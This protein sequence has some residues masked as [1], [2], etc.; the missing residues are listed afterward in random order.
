MDQINRSELRRLIEMDR[1]PCVS[2]YLPTHRAGAD[3]LQDPIRLK[4][5]VREAE[6]LLGERSDQAPSIRD[7]LDPLRDLVDQYQFWQHQ[8]DGLA[9]FRSRDIFCRYRLSFTVPELAVAAPRFHLKPLLPA[10]EANQRFHVLALSQDAARV[11][12]GNSQSITEIKIK[13]MPEGP[14]ISSVSRGTERQLQSHTTGRESSRRRGAVFHGQGAGEEDRRQALL[15]YFRRVDETVRK[16]TDEQVPVV[17][18]AVD[19]LCPIYR[20]ASSNPNLLAEEIHGNPE[21]HSS[22][23]LHRL[24]WTIASSH[25]KEGQIKAADEYHQLWHTQRAS[26]DIPQIVTAARQ[27]RVKLLFVAVGLQEWAQVDPQRAEIVQSDQRS[28]HDE[29]LLNLA[30]IDTFIA[31]GCVYAV[32]PVEVPGRGLAAAV[33]R[34]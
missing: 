9:L 34:Y 27:G 23:E 18:A 22:E 7:L 1:Q 24:A 21:G 10:V 12:E 15:S 25:F 11:Y 30:A 14:F 2:I 33:F 19:Y 20:H 6:R 17:L 4:N 13:N 8:E 16:L 32:P 29:D 28:A 3:T 26:K 31:G 5:L